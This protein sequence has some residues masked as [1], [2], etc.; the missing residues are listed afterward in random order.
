[1]KKKNF[2]LAMACACALTVGTVPTSVLAE[3]T[4]TE[5][6]A[7]TEDA[8]EESTEAESE[9]EE[10]AEAVR[11]T[12]TALD[13]V[14]LGE[15]KG[16]TVQVEAKQEI[17]DEEVEAEAASLIL[18][19]VTEGTVEEGDIADI[20]YVGTM[21]GEEFS[22]GSG[23]YSLEIGSGTFI[24]GFEEGLVG[25]AIGDTVDL[26]LTFPED[27]YYEDLAG[28]DVV[29]TVTVN[30]VQR[31]GEVTDENVAS[32][33]DGEYE[34]AESFLAYVR[35][36]MEADVDADW[37]YV[38]YEAIYEELCAGS[39]VKEYPQDLVDYCREQAIESYEYYATLYE[40]DYETLIT[41]WFGSVEEFESELDAAIESSLQQ[42]LLLMAV[43]E[44]EGLDLTDEEYA[45]GLERYAEDY[46][47]SSGEE[48]EAEYGEADLRRYITLDKVYDFLLE[49]A[50]IEEITETETES[51]IETEAAD[52]IDTEEDSEA[53]VLTETG[54][55]T[56]DET[57]AESE[58]ET[59]TA[60][61]AE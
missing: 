39:E 12:Y 41:T 42:E 35:S 54:S 22:G 11:P 34:D 53:E 47:Y 8:A 29:F 20:S 55:D 50:V 45:E 17:T 37:E 44:T 52:E 6:A 40:V 36:Y 14:V 43:C 31:A 1:M 32:A 24:D 18:M 57:E 5:T 2:L 61:E 26:D 4:E 30:S 21:D 60:A 3:E 7:E 58:T 23:D 51:E 13:Y 16:I 19:T 59:E 38:A 46:G 27:Y 28:Q 48:I 56:A 15:Y 10:E 49:N 33:T 25:V 9:T